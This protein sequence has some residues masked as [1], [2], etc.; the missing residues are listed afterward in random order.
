[1]YV[2]LTIHLFLTAL[3]EKNRQST[4]VATTNIDKK[5]RLKEFVD[6][7]SITNVNSLNEIEEIDCRHD[8][9]YHKKVWIGLQ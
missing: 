4:I 1:M 2:N 8:N 7:K 9:G 5:K 6:D 3:L